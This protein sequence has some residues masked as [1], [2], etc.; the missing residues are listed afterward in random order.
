MFSSLISPSTC[1][2]QRESLMRSMRGGVS[3]EAAVSS[4]S[5][6]KAA[7]KFLQL[8]SSSLGGLTAQR[9]KA[10]GHGPS[11]PAA[12]GACAEWRLAAAQLLLEAQAGTALLA[13]R[14]AKERS[15]LHHAAASG[16]VEV[17]RLLLRAGAARDVKDALMAPMRSYIVYDVTLRAESTLV[18]PFFGTGLGRV[19][20]SCRVRCGAA[21]CTRSHVACPRRFSCE[22]SA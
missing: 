10:H 17:I 14:D 9:L 21:V 20:V 7:Q 18:G 3:A 16:D 12:R 5:H 8:P 13:T 6:K 11:G 22:W 19:H 4:L 15:S 2:F 1:L